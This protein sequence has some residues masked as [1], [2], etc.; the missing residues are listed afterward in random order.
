MKGNICA[1][2]MSSLFTLCMSSVMHL[3]SRAFSKQMDF[4]S[5]VFWVSLLKLELKDPL[6]ASLLSCETLTWRV[7]SVT[8]G[9]RI[10]VEAIWRVQV[11]W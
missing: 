10:Q 1:F 11:I 7:H 2:S 8:T 9:R 4:V 3:H 6:R 5:P